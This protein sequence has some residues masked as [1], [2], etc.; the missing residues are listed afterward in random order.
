[1]TQSIMSRRALCAGASMFVAFSGGVVRTAAAQA[2]LPDGDAYSPWTLWNDRSI[3]G[4]PLA[5]VAAAVLAANPHNTQPWLFH[6]R[7]DSIEIYAD[8]ARNLGAMDAFVRE[9]HLALGC[10]VQNLL[11]AAPPNGF[12]TELDVV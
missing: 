2:A 11:L 8:L 3:H 10:A 7:Q 12:D 6:V 4:T 1:M 5:L 9:M